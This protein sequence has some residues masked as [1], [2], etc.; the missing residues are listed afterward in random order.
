[1]DA[2]ARA[3][4]ALKPAKGRGYNPRPG[5]NEHVADLH[6]AARD[7][8]FLWR[9]GGKPKHGPV[10]D[11]KRTCCLQVCGTLHKEQ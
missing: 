1:M 4:T 7:A 2:V 6:S 8:F 3:G 5:W 10:F 11:M 9:D